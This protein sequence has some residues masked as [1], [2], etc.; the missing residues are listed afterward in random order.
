M[1]KTKPAEEPSIVIFL[2]ED[3]T[4]NKL[5]IV[6]DTLN[7]AEADNLIQGLL[8]LYAVYYLMDLNYPIHYAQILGLIQQCCLGI[9]FQPVLRSAA[10]ISFKESLMFVA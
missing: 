2:N 5:F 10:F 1:L 6:G 7:I 3:G 4:P 8:V 9:E